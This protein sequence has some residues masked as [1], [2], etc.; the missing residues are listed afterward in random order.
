VPK[1]LNLGIDTTPKDAKLRTGFDRPRVTLRN[2]EISL[3]FHE[4]SRDSFGF[5]AQGSNSPPKHW[6]NPEKCSDS[7]IHNTVHIVHIDTANS[8]I[9]FEQGAKFHSFNDSPQNNLSA[10]GK[11]QNLHNLPLVPKLTKILDRAKFHNQAG[12]RKEFDMG[13]N[14]D[15]N[16]N[17]TRR[18][19]ELCPKN[20]RFKLKNSSFYVNGVWFVEHVNIYDIL[21]IIELLGRGRTAAVYSCI[22]RE[23]VSDRSVVNSDVPHSAR[24]QMLAVKIFHKKSHN[25]I[26]RKLQI[27]TEINLLESLHHKNIL[28]FDSLY[29]DRTKI[30]L[31]TELC[32][33][34]INLHSYLA[35][36]NSKPIPK[37]SLSISK[38]IV[39]S[40]AHCHAHNITHLDLNLTNILINPNTTQIKIIDFGSSAILGQKN[41]S[42]L[43]STMT[44]AF[45]P[46]EII[47]SFA[48][49]SC[50]S[51]RSVDVWSIGVLIY[52][53]S[54]GEYPF[55]GGNNLKVVKKNI[56]I[57]N[58]CRVGRGEGEGEG[59]GGGGLGGIIDRIFGV[60]G[61]VGGGERPGLGVVRIF[62]FWVKDI[63]DRGR[64]GCDGKEV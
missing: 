29:E 18:S 1:N 31:L 61:G 60:G 58:Y 21:E 40:I 42:D 54:M 12:I 19:N 6:L 16:L 17:S 7:P 34:H 28:K 5:V 52:Y 53:V 43:I 20:F 11:S 15:S 63:L 48:R 35:S 26:S 36:Q 3:D 55:G 2:D 27:M 33:N 14:Y 24:P 46:P 39:S 25:E 30:Y 13:S 57:G 8:T 51:Y 45:M 62:F 10:N 37:L 50:D 38:Q 9:E 32:E 64:V 47:S 41:H 56:D 23:G 44:P 4:N 49:M 22:K 59:E